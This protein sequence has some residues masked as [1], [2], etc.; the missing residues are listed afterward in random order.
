VTA[1]MQIASYSLLVAFVLVVSKMYLR[2]KA[3]PQPGAGKGGW[4]L[5]RSKVSSRRMNLDACVDNIELATVAVELEC[6]TAP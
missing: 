1:V 6:G 2:D 4:T 5:I 3:E